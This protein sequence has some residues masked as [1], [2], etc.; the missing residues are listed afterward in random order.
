MIKVT[1]FIFIKARVCETQILIA[2]ILVTCIVHYT[3]CERD[4]YF[5]TITTESYALIHEY[6]YIFDNNEL[7]K[8]AEMEQGRCSNS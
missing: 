4:L 3:V 5:S 2:P 7:F 1:I 6:T 8:I